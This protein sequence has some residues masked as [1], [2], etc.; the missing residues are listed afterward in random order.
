LMRA[1]ATQCKTSP[2]TQRRNPPSPARPAP[3]RHAL[4]RGGPDGRQKTQHKK[5]PLPRQQPGR[6]RSARPSASSAS[7]IASKK[8]SEYR[9]AAIQ[10]AG[11]RFCPPPYIGLLPAAACCCLLLPAGKDLGRRKINLAR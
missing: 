9:T 1:C 10:I 8:G 2:A 4:P 11:Q 6:S 7:E 5:K 3:P